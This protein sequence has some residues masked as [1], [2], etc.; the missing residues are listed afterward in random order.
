MINTEDTDMERATIRMG[1]S[2][3][4]VQLAGMVPGRALSL[5]ESRE[6][7]RTAPAYVRRSIDRYRIARGMMPLWQE[8][9]AASPA[10][11]Q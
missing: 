11:G 6:R 2:G 1:D 9:P 5:D 8:A 10:T 4:V 7:C 3:V